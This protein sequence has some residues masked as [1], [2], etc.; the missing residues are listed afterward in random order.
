MMQR[1]DYLLLRLE[2]PLMA[3]GGPV[4][5]QIGPTRSFPG[6]AQLAGLLGNALGYGHHQATLL[7]DLQERIQFG[8]LLLRPGERLMDYQTVDLGQAHLKG[9][10]WTT[11]GRMEQRQGASSET[12]H[13][14]QRWHLA[15]ALVLVALTLL[16]P[17]AAPTLAQLAVALDHPAR[18]LFI[19]RKPCL[20]TAPLRLGMAAQETVEG[21][22]RQ[23]VRC[24]LGG[25]DVASGT[26]LTEVDAR[27]LGVEPAAAEAEHLVDRRDWHNQMHTGARGIFRY[28]SAL[29]A[30]A[31]P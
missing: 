9:T 29:A 7:Q 25:V 28:P 24:H 16:P 30:E 15:D 14:R 11:R 3:F 20:P 18:P 10:G 5:D 19:G 4:V 12:T 21:A 13:I 31:A 17:E 26:A 2:A 27:L 6:A 8:C 23:A 1:H 22:L